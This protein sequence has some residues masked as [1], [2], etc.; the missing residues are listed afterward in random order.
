MTASSS[1]RT[2]AAV[3]V[4][5][6]MLLTIWSA[7]NLYSDVRASHTS[8]PVR[9]AVYAARVNGS[10]VAQLAP[11][12]LCNCT[13]VAGINMTLFPSITR[14]INA[15]V[16]TDITV[17]VPATITMTDVFSVTLSSGVWSKSIYT[18][19]PNQTSVSDTTFASTQ[20]R[21]A[22][23]VSSVERE[24][25]SI[26]NSTQYPAT[27]VSVTLASEVL[28]SI[29]VS[30]TTGTLSLESTGNLTFFPDHIQTGFATRSFNGDVYAP[31]PPDGAIPASAYLLVAIMAVG[32][33]ASVI[34]F[35]A[36]SSPRGTK[37]EEAIPALEDLIAPYEEVIADTA[38]VPDPA[39]TVRIDRWE[40]LV[41]ISDTLG[42]P[43]LRPSGGKPLAY[44]TS[45]YVLDGDIGYLYRYGVSGPEPGP[46]VSTAA[47]L[48]GG[49]HETLRRVR[50]VASRIESLPPSDARFPRALARFRRLRA[51]IQAHRWIEAERV[52]SE[53]EASLSAV[54]EKTTGSSKEGAAPSKDN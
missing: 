26:E 19:P 51:L 9:V 23:N 5:V 37:D 16:G 11:N 42:K 49:P 17:D 4:V 2:V 34:W 20:D 7:Y 25:A 48:P 45:F 41:K 27:S 39:A 29:A 44:R 28:V 13:E 15:T 6:L 12:T 24:I 47:D 31:G 14:V 10:F 21:F 50:V 32:L 1:L 8:A 40:G 54:P 53:L 46:S 18:S 35:A 43:I 38:S 36:L 52:L 30:G 3:L 33:I 22:S